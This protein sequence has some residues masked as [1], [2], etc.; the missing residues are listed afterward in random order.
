MSYL[1]IK[2]LPSYRWSVSQY[3][4][5]LYCILNQFGCLL[6]AYLVCVVLLWYCCGTVVV[7]LW[8]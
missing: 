2:L 8:Y 6:W 5:A 1:D 4:Y 3:L 7:L